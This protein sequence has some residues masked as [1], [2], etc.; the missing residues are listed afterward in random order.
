[1]PGTL[2]M[3]KQKTGPRGSNIADLSRW[4]WGI[5][6]GNTGKLVECRCPFN[7]IDLGTQ[8]TLVPVVRGVYV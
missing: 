8:C 1:M 3:I 5:V 7:G 4:K 2:L 6:T